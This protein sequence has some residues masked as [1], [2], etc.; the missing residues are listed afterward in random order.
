MERL[1]L[2]GLFG[3]VSGAGEES[4]SD[5]R[6]ALRAWLIVWSMAVAFVL[7]GLL[8]FFVI[9]DKGPPDWDMGSVEDVPGASVY[10][11]HPYE[12]LS[13]EPAPQNVSERPSKVE[14]W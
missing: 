6:R 5:R 8:A 2:E 11:T 12:G 10:S 3:A 14:Q 9:G 7:Y 13:S 4:G 1:E